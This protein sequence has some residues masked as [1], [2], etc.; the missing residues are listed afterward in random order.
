VTVIVIVAVYLLLAP[1]VSAAPGTADGHDGRPQDVI[2]ILDD[3]VPAAAT[4]AALERS[5]EFSATQIWSTALVGFSARLTGTQLARIRATRGVSYVSADA[6]VRLLGWTSVQVGEDEPT[7]V[8]RIEAAS[9]VA[10]H[11]ASPVSVAVLD[12]GIDLST[13]D[14]KTC[15][16]GTRSAQDDNGHGTYVSGTVAAQNN[17]AGLVGVSPGTRVVAVKVLDR[18]GNGSISDLICGIDWTAAHAKTLNIRIANLSLG[19]A[20]ASDNNCGRWNHDALHHAIC[21]AAAK[22]ITFVAAAGN[23]GADFATVVPAAY[24][25]VLTV[26]AMS[27][28]DGSP[29]AK[30][31]SP[32]CAP[33]EGDD[34]RATFSNFAL[35]ASDRSHTIA[36]PGVCI[37]STWLGGGFAVASGTSAAAPHVAGTIALCV[38]SGNTPGPCDGLE[39]AAT[40]ARVRD[41]AATRSGFPVAPAFGFD[42][43]PDHAAGNRY[44]GYLVW[45]GGY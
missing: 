44:F 7:G 24:P 25:E 1:M 32:A 2:V 38:G 30:G 22:G 31:S 14:G 13:L 41:A 27:D 20:G 11:E 6:Q 45:A 19:T 35:G 39:P 10:V 33:A 29:G 4:T 23:D 18:L 26:T 15:V 16:K 5:I 9:S 17:G 3:G 36:A 21:G 37:R 40:I 12:T 43:D 34:A 8:R 28:S 42:G